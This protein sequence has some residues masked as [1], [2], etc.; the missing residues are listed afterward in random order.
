MTKV[1]QRADR[2]SQIPQTVMAVRNGEELPKRE[3]E[4]DVEDKNGG[5]GVHL[6]DIR[7]TFILDNE[8]WRYD[9]VPEIMD[10]RNVADFVDPDI[11]AKLA[12]LER[13][14]ELLFQAAIPTQDELDQEAH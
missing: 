10:G 1:E 3:L 12:E 8:A 2:P 9:Q 11:D 13:E 4:K 7:K 5:A 6:Y 14:E